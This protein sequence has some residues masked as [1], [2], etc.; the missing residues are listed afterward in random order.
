MN[1]CLHLISDV[2]EKV[3]DSRVVVFDDNLKFVQNVRKIE[4]LNIY[5]FFICF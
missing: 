1:F 4:E 3:P 5:W 2:H